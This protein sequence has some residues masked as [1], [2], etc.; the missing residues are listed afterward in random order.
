MSEISEISEMSN[1]MFCVGYFTPNEKDNK[2]NIYLIFNPIIQSIRY[3]EICAEY[4]NNGSN[5]DF[6]C[7]VYKNK[8]ILGAIFDDKRNNVSVKLIKIG[9]VRKIFNKIFI[10]KPEHLKHNKF[11]HILAGKHIMNILDNIFYLMALMNFNIDLYNYNVV[12]YEI[13]EITEMYFLIM[14]FKTNNVNLKKFNKV[15]I[16]HNNKIF[17]YIFNFINL[18]QLT[19]ESTSTATATSTL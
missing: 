13:E 8:D 10:N 7:Y 9:N 18:S 2:N 15:F 16:I 19:I 5:S 4:N 1:N 14:T 12:L 11:R 6:V 17:K 3:L